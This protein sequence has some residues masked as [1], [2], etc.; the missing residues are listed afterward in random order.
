M[1]GL[2]Q[3]ILRIEYIIKKS[4]KKYNRNHDNLLIIT[5]LLEL[6]LI[7]PTLFIEIGINVS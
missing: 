5:N 7:E 3:C 2:I 4:K 1:K 6:Q